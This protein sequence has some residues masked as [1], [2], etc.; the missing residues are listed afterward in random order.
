[1]TLDEN[2]GSFAA[3]VGSRAAI[4]VGANRE[5]DEG[6]LIIDDSSRLKIDFSGTRGVIDLRI[7]N[8][9]SY[10]IRLIDRQG[11]ENPDPIEYMVTAVPDEYPTIGVLYPGFDLNLDE[12]MTIPFKL[13]I[14]DDFGFSSLVLKYQIVSGGKK[15]DENVAV[16]NFSDKI[17]TEGEV[18]FTWDLDGFN[19]LP[20][21]FVL[22]H[23]ELADND[24]V[25]GPKVTSTRVYAARLPSI[26]EIV[27]QTETEQEG[28]VFES[29][30]LL[31]EQREM[32]EKL[33]QLATQMKAAIISTGSRKKT[34]KISCSSSS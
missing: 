30:R 25:S 29:E 16:I 34:S 4:E 10:H 11:E 1:L 2:N 15:G 27:M 26:D 24:K 21:D 3:L 28:R 12:N 13:Q 18:T 22:Y 19:L 20:A 6:Y 32:A 31:Q 23:F 17:E 7:Q 5:I 14:S 9:F 33:K 8:D